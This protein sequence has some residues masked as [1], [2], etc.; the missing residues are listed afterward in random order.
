MLVLHES[1]LYFM[2][3]WDMEI[4]LHLCNKYSFTYTSLG[5]FLCLA[6][7]CTP[8]KGCVHIGDPSG[9]DDG[10]MFIGSPVTWSALGCM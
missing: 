8:R 7:N 10:L 1:H 2:F 5:G 4:I 9:K 3:P 6:T